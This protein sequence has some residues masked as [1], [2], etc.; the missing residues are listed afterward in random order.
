MPIPWKAALVS[1]KLAEN[2]AVLST[3]KAKID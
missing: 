1:S 3:V 2:K